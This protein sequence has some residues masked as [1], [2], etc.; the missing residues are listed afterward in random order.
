[1]ERPVR[2]KRASVERLK[3]WL[4]TGRGQPPSWYIDLIVAEKLGIDP[5]RLRTYP[6]FWR[7][8]VLARL[9]AEADKAKHDQRLTQ[10]HAKFSR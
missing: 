3:S 2:P 9:E 1:M 10:A 8:A 5:E 4:R 7:N 6:I